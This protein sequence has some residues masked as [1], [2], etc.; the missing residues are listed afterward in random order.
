MKQSLLYLGKRVDFKYILTFFSLSPLSLLLFHFVFDQPTYPHVEMQCVTHQIPSDSP[1]LASAFYLFTIGCIYSLSSPSASVYASPSHFP[2]PPSNNNNERNKRK[3]KGKRKKRNAF[4]CTIVLIMM[5][6]VIPMGLLN[7]DD[8][9]YIQ[10]SMFRLLF[11][12]PSPFSLSSS[13][14]SPHSLLLSSSF[15]L[16]QVD[17]D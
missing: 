9:I 16:L 3:G 15:L 13:S 1:F 8:N 17:M 14:F 2:S 7:L 10:V 11:L 5:V 6:A 4:D 12:L